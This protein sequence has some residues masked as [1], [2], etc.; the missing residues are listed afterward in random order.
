MEVILQVWAFLSSEGLDIL[1]GLLAGLG[2]LKAIAR[3][4]AWE[5]DDKALEFIEKPLVL[6]R[7]LIKKGKP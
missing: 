2:A 3:Y 5:W 7:D 4:T 6:V 1:V